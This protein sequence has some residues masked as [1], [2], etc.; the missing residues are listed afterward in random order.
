MRQHYLD[1][2]RG[3]PVLLLHG[4]PSWSYLWRRLVADLR[5]DHRCIAP[6]HIGMGWSDRPRSSAYPYTALR[7]LADLEDLMDHLVGDKDA[8]KDGWTLVA[9]DWGGAIGMAWARR[10]P[11]RV[12]RLV[13]LNTAAFPWPPGYRLPPVVDL[14]RRS[15]LV[16]AAAHRANAFVRAS[17]RLGTVQPMPRSVRTAFTAPYR[18]LRNRE[19]IVRFVQDIPLSRQDPSWPLVSSAAAEETEHLRHLPTFIGWGDQDPVF[20]PAIA[21]EWQRRL[22]HAHIEH[23]PDAGHYVLEDAHERLV[24]AI[25]TFL[26]ANP[27]APGPTGRKP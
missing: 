14:I 11:G 8:P 16:A 17:V 26:T 23:Y 4:N 25:R 18:A 21:R 20:T 22:P 12:A 27:P 1:E 24:P 13:L 2:G 5:A 6:D 3:A 19:A 7:R 10:H 9:H 15:P